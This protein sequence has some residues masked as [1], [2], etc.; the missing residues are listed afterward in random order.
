MSRILDKKILFLFYTIVFCT[1]CF[2]QTSTDSLSFNI[3]F[4]KSISSIDDLEDESL[5]D[6]I[7]N[8]IFGDDNAILNK[9]TGVIALPNKEIIVLDQGLYGLVSI[10]LDENNINKLNSEFQFPSLVS[11]CNYKENQML[12][13]DSKNNRIYVIDAEEDIYLLNDTLLINKPTGIGYVNSTKEIWVS[14]TGTHSILVLDNQGIFKKRIG[15]RGT[16][17]GKF[18]FPTSI[19]VG[20]EENI[21]VVD[22]IN[23]RIQIFD[24]SGNLIR[25]FGEQGDAT[26]YFARP[27]GIA[28][29]AF[30]NIY[31]VDALF[32]TVQIFNNEGDFLYNFG[33]Q[34]KE[35]GKFW[36]P[37]GIY[38]DEQN[39]IYIADSYNSRIQI[40][41]LTRK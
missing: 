12:L 15:I 18:N 1:C 8:L 29:D 33:S 41:Q 36:L 2:A 27:K 19:W 6:K 24:K 5:L 20:N 25:M 3:N 35:D 31:V 28:T 22:A 17:K 40:F 16:N 34:G 13:T 7:G 39:Y 38:I 26:G 21:Y 10:D 9:P 14:E 37:N 11:I 32:H 30:G 23:F 4:H